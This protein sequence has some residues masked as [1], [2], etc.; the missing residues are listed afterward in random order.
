[1]RTL[2]LVVLFAATAHAQQKAPAAPPPMPKPPAEM[3]VERWFVGSWTCEGKQAAGPWGPEQ[4]TAN[5]LDFKMEMMDFWLEFRGEATTGPMKGHE[6]LEG[7]A[8]YDPAQKKHVRID[9]GMMGMITHS[10]SP[11][12]EGDKLVFTGDTAM[13][14]KKM[15]FK[16]TMTKKGDAEFSGV[17][18]MDGKPM[19]TETCKKAK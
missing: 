10:S 5:K 11:G 2:A 7:F 13:G 6:M 12:W 1:M 9:F 19:G 14:G 15:A 18:E 4:K 16:H 3:S 17:V 8:T